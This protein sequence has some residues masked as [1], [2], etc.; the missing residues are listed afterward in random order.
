MVDT[1][2]ELVEVRHLCRVGYR[3][4]VLGCGRFLPLVSDTGCFVEV[5]LKPLHKC[6][7][8]VSE[9][10]VGAAVS[11]EVLECAVPISPITE[12]LRVLM[13]SLA[14]HP[15]IVEK[16]G[17]KF[18]AVLE[19][20]AT[21]LKLDHSLRPDCIGKFESLFV[22]LLVSSCLLWHEVEVEELVATFAVHVNVEVEGYVAVPQCSLSDADWLFRFFHVLVC[23]F[24]T[25]V[26]SFFGVT[27]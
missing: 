18:I 4:H 13:P 5:V 22:L 12:A 27:K 14:E 7:G 21:V 1:G 9:R 26:T 24:V 19:T 3:L 6:R 17:V 11:F 10:H 16:V 25:R 8:H 15:V 23:I 2:S 20:E